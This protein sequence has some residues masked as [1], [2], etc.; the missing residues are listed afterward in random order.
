MTAMGMLETLAAELNECGYRG[1]LIT[2]VLRDM[3][4]SR[5]MSLNLLTTQQLNDGDIMLLDFDF[6]FY[7][8][9]RIELEGLSAALT[10][11]KVR[12]LL[13]PMAEP[14]EIWQ[15]FDGLPT[16]ETVT[17]TLEGAEKQ[18]AKIIHHSFN[19]IKDMNLNNLQNLK[20]EV[21]E[22]RFSDKLLPQMEQN[23]QKSLPEFQ[24]HDSRPGSKGQVDFTLH[25]KKS[26]QSDFFYLNKYDVYLNK[27]TPLEE[28]QK[29]MVLSKNEEDKPVFRS[30]VN[31][32]EAIDYFKNQKGDS[33][34][35]AGKSPA[36]KTT[37]ASMEKGKV[38]YVA[39]EFQ[40]TYYAPPITH[41]MY[42][43]QGKGFTSEQAANLIEGRSV[44][45]DDLLNLGGQPYKAWVV[46][47]M[48]KG[49]DRNNNFQ[50]RQFHD[51]S[52]GFNL[53]E[54]LAEYNIK[55]LADPAK[56]EKIDE[57]LRNGNRPLITTV[58]DGKEVKLRI[59]AVPR[60]GK[61]NFFQEN[62]KPEKREQFEV[63]QKA[64]PVLGKA[65]GKEL[66]LLFG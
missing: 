9:G 53:K 35:A 28:G 55:E 60:Y 3:Y 52:Y 12:Q 43:E 34:L 14:K 16:I 25:F 31:P 36:N 13:Y 11:E 44:Y 39:K 2:E 4:E 15:H 20:D 49:K 40:K 33:E 30:F 46:F 62:G 54:A 58:Q 56:A 8:A 23:M 42:V 26:G 59:E 37:L 48:D 65:N 24:L 10:S 19:S 63:N 61:I 32:H 51:P 66:A 41:T 47:D 22:L 29:Y 64:A 21:K 7:P 17:N 50:T 6:H 1:D 57:A 38:N 27:A 45:R 18:E 5:N